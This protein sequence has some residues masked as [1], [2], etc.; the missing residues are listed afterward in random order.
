MVNFT[1]LTLIVYFLLTGHKNSKKELGGN[2]ELNWGL[3]SCMES[4]NAKA[5]KYSFVF[6]S[7]TKEFPQFV[8]ANSH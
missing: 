7:K 4:G 2:M 3:L 6:Y 5:L 1:I 8:R